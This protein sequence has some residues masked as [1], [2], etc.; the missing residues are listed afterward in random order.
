MALLI[1]PSATR[2]EFT[3]AAGIASGSITQ[4]AVF[5]RINPKT[6]ITFNDDN[7]VYN[8]TSFAY[9]L[10]GATSNRLRVSFRTTAG[11]V[12][13]YKT[14]T[15]FDQYV[16]CLTIVDFVGGVMRHYFDGVQEGADISL[17]G[18][19][20]LTTTLQLKVA[21]A[22]ADRTFEY[23]RIA[24]WRN[25][26]PTAGDI[27][28]LQNGDAFSS[29]TNPPTAYYEPTGT[30]GAYVSSL[31]DDGG[32]NDMAH[33]QGPTSGGSEPVYSGAT[34]SITLP[35]IDRVIGVSGN[36]NAATFTLTGDYAGVD[37]D[38]IQIRITSG[39]SALSGFDWITVS[40][41]GSNSWSHTFTNVPAGAP[42]DQYVIQIRS[43]DAVDAEIS[44]ASS[45]VTNVGI[46]LLAYGQSNMTRQIGSPTPAVTPSAG[47]FYKV[48]AASAATQSGAA[49]QALAN[50]IGSRTGKAVLVYFEGQGATPIADLQ[51]GSTIWDTRVE[52]LLADSININAMAYV[53]GENDVG[54]ASATYKAALD[55]Y[56]T[57][58]LA[59]SGQSAENFTFLE[60]QTGRLFNSTYTY[61]TNWV[62]IR[63]TQKEWADETTSARFAAATIDAEHAPDGGEPHGFDPYHYS[64]EWYAYDLNP[65]I[66]KTYANR[67]GLSSSDGTGPYL[68]SFYIDG[69]DIRARVNLNGATS[70][71]STGTG[72]LTG[73]KLWTDN[74]FTTEVTISAS[75]IDGNE[76][77]ITPA[78][79]PTESMTLANFRETSPIITNSVAGTGYDINDIGLQ[80]SVAEF[81]AQTGGF[82]N[83][84]LSISIGIGI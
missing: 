83:D 32:S 11:T 84:G 55:S 40:S 44:S 9:R 69:S 26:I 75:S 59:I 79:A 35:T 1:P 16:N 15:T 64:N 20:L 10:R 57:R 5:T 33:T 12:D 22:T 42:S 60:V 45:T 58:M 50:Q 19:S 24:E 52:P 38:D 54:T 62:N 21:G 27:T 6:A 36:T 34:N 48:S 66:A 77:L 67:L 53:Q 76:L 51:P 41:F 14:I 71:V 23:E 81:S 17:S 37:P 13:R 82:L 78:I 47:C 18:D 46:A 7:L 72:N 49:I 80:M 39:G 31:A 29:L 4:Y 63:N 43:L 2:N 73:L 30:N 3:Q 8:S 74:T 56:I 28:A 65:R 70:L 25:S 61:A 68:T